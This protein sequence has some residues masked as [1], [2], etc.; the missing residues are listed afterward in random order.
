MLSPPQQAEQDAW[1]RAERERI[2]APE[3]VEVFGRAVG[4]LLAGLV[5]TADPRERRRIVG[6][7]HA[8]CAEASRLSARRGREAA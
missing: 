2:M 3:P 8:M 4:E 6:L 1:C 5:Y 7:L